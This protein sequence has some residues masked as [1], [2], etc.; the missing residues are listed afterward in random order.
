M[1]GKDSGR[2]RRNPPDSCESRK[3]TATL[4]RKWPRASMD[5]TGPGG[6]PLPR[7][8]SVPVFL[9]IS[10]LFESRPSRYFRLNT[11]LMHIYVI[12]CN[13]S[14]VGIKMTRKC[15]TITINVLCMQGMIRNGAGDRS[16]LE[17]S[18][19][20]LGFFLWE[21]AESP[22]TPSEFKPTSLVISNHSLE[23]DVLMLGSYC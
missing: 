5:H 8:G 21:V 18:Q 4:G 12:S 16:K 20:S 22:P 3:L 1:T 11:S 19:G 9:L 15:V 23:L 10:L 2:G 17:T 14:R 13:H 6:F 7:D